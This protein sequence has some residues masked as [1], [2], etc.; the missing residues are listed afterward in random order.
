MAAV[1]K[2]T[3]VVRGLMPLR[4]V[5][6]TLSLWLLGTASVSGEAPD[7]KGQ[8]TWVSGDHP[9]FGGLGAGILTG[10]AG[11]KPVWIGGSRVNA[12]NPQVIFL[13]NEVKEDVLV[14][15]D[16][17]D[18]HKGPHINLQG[19]NLAKADFSAADSQRRQQYQQNQFVMSTHT[20]T[21]PVGSQ[22]V[23]TVRR[24]RSFEHHG[25]VN[26]CKSAVKSRRNT[27]SNRQSELLMHAAAPLKGRS[28]S[29]WPNFG[30]SLG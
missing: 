23:R 14:R 29:T 22:K 11:E 8:A 21:D 15:I 5:C 6:A 3:T 7:A 4:I 30:A 27:Q 26:P 9:Q 1:R 16:I 18:P 28:V 20:H 12:Q 19:P 24:Q 2:C 10:R 13:G 25:D 17:E